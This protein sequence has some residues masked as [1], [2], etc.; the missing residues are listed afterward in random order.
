MFY[1]VLIIMVF[2]LQSVLMGVCGQYPDC[3]NLAEMAEEN[4]VLTPQLY[5]D[6]T[7]YDT[8]CQGHAY[9]SFGFSLTSAETDMVGD[10]TWTRM[11]TDAYGQI[12]TVRLQLYMM[13]N[14]VLTTLAQSEML[15][16]GESVTIHAQG[17]IPGGTPPMDPVQVGYIQCT[18]GSFV[19]PEDWPCGKIAQGVVFYVEGNGYHGWVVSLHD[20]DNLQWCTIPG[21]NISSLANI[22][23]YRV[24]LRT[25]D[26]Y[27]NTQSIMQQSGY[28]ATYPAAAACDFNHG[29]Y[30]PAMGQLYQLYVALIPV[31]ESLQLVGG[32]LFPR[33][34]NR[35]YWSSSGYEQGFAWY[36][37][38][39]GY[40]SGGNKTSS[41]SVRSVRTF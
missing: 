21:D 1:K 28:P 38:S 32:H 14:P 12:S 22:L 13:G 24:I 18:D 3:A 41:Y 40:L 11:D 4:D 29:W 15:C 31:N 34:A 25:V 20:Q 9:N 33:D 17:S 23:D 30:L 35:Q 16:P 10:Y 26:G 39:N 5:Q 2:L 19:S 8:I 7:Y 37:Q 36:L 6:T 27:A